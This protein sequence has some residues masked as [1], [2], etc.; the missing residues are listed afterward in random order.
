VWG[1][2]NGF[3]SWPGKI[4]SQDEDRSRCW[5]CWFTTKQVTQVEKSRLK[6]LSEGLEDHHRERKNSRKGKKNISLEKAIQEAMSEL[7]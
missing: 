5:V 4:V 2:A 7:D 1:P 3:S 6:T